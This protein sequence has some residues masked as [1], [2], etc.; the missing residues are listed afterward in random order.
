MMQLPQVIAFHR[1]R[2]I[3]LQ[4]LSLYF[5]ST[6]FILAFPSLVGEDGNLLF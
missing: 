2:I 5:P 1:Q 3:L 4:R 6:I